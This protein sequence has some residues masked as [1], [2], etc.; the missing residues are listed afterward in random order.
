MLADGGIESAIRQTVN[1]R[2][3]LL[4]AA[5]AIV[6]TAAMLID[7][8]RNRNCGVF[9]IVATCLTLIH[10]KWTVSAIS[11]DLGAS[12]SLYSMILTTIIVGLMLAMF[13]SPQ[14][15]RNSYP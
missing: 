12:Q 14:N 13:F 4:C 3:S 7:Y 1:V 6:A 15:R 8:F 11:G 2:L 10:P 5:I 9:V